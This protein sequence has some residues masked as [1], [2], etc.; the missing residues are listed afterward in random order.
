MFL[1]FL[2]VM[3]VVYVVGVVFVNLVVEI[4]L[5]DLFFFFV[6]LSIVFIFCLLLLILMVLLYVL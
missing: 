1:L 5:V 6:C 4:R 3:C 2:E